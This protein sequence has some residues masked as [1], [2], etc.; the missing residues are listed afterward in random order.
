MTAKFEIEKFNGNNF[1]LWKLKMKVILTKVKC[2]AAIGERLAEV[3][4]NSKWDEMNGN[5][6]ENLHLTLADGV[7]SNIEEKKTAKD[8]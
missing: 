4:D 2:L 3:T 6:M 5:A 8:I 1:L 7:L